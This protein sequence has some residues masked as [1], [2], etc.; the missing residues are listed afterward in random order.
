M[1]RMLLTVLIS[2]L[3]VTAVFGQ[4]LSIQGV[5]R[6]DTGASVDGSKSFKFLLYTV[7]TGGTK[8]WDEDQTINV[9]NGVYSATLG[10]VNTLAGLNY[11]VSYWLGISI[12]GAT[13]MTPRT[14]LT[15]SPYAIAGGVQGTKNVFPQSGIVGIGTLSPSADLHIHNDAV[16]A[17]L[18]I[19][20]K[21]GYGLHMSTW[22]S[23]NR[24]NFGP[25]IENGHFHFGR[26]IA[27][28]GWYFESGNVGIGTTVPIS[29]LHVHDGTA[30]ISKSVG[31][32][33]TGT[34]TYL[35][36]GMNQHQSDDSYN[37][38]F[39]FD[40]EATAAI[41]QSKMHLRAGKAE[42]ADDQ[43]AIPDAAHKTEIMTFDGYGNVGIGTTSP[44]RA[45][46]V[47][48]G[49]AAYN[50]NSYNIRIE[51]P[52]G[53]SAAGF[54]WDFGIDNDPGDEDLIF[55]SKNGCEAYFDDDDGAFLHSSDRR[56]KKN[57]EPA[58]DLLDKVMQLQPSVY[59]M[60]SQDDSES[61]NL[62]FIAQDVQAVFPDQMVVGE[63]G[64]MLSLKYESF[65]VMAIAAIQ[66][67][68]GIIENQQKEIDDLKE[69]L[70]RIEASLRKQ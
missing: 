40:I 2:V 34:Y 44:Q 58:G 29:K 25:A 27:A 16:S 32:N 17:A 62:G 30:Y 66:E 10:A 47:I 67:Q 18:K 51:V 6:D 69:R 1:K 70:A 31:Y 41:K 28:S 68:Q 35:L 45:L 15:L 26:D 21:N 52:S 9:V 38:K 49:S 22:G 63:H 11:S 37:T 43:Y 65:S 46:H 39:L 64:G 13:E 42:W 54:Y 3:F 8:V 56:L 19:T 33:E 14:K 60:K 12:E 48:G 50:A 24:F 53:L 5:L 57:I 61:K 36:M 55:Y 20:N 23:D 7:E 4:T 59:H